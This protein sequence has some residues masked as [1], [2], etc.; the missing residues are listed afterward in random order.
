MEDGTPVRATLTCSLKEW[1]TNKEDRQRQG[2]QSNDLAKRTSLRRGDT[3]STIAADEYG[4]PE[5]WRPIAAANDLDDPLR[6]PV[7]RSLT[8][9][10]LPLNPKRPTK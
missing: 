6:L 7:G 8:V 2:L 3:L 1:R 9:P 10:R 4:D 5:M